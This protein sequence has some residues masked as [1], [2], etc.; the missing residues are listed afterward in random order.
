MNTEPEGADGFQ[1]PKAYIAAWELTRGCTSGLHHLRGRK[2][3]EPRGK[4]DVYI[5]GEDMP[6]VGAEESGFVRNGAS[7]FVVKAQVVSCQ[8]D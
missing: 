1:P 4:V 3:V 6:D 5:I 7:H 2:A 8:L